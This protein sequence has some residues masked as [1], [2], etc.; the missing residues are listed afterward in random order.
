ML[1]KFGR[2]FM[3]L[4]KLFRNPLKKSENSIAMTR[5]FLMGSAFIKKYLSS[6]E[7]LNTQEIFFGYKN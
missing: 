4:F 3:K 1:I 5:N 2:T 6:N 7:N